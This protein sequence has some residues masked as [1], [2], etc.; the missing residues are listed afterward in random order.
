MANSGLA[1]LPPANPPLP[2]FDKRQKQAPQP[3]ALPADQAAAVAELRAQLPNLTVD[4]EPVTGSP[5]SVSAVE[6]FLSGAGGKGKAIS[7]SGLAGIAVDD[8]Y[9][10]TK[11][12]LQDHRR[13][14]GF[15]PE[16]LDNARITREFVTA[17]NGLRT[18]VWEQ[19]AEGIAVFEAVLISHTTSKSELVNISSQFVPDPSAAANNGAP[20]RAALVA[21]SAVTASQAVALAAQNVGVELKAD[22]VTAASEPAAG[23]EQR[24]KFKAPGLKGEADAKLIWLPM[25]KN[26]LRLCWDVILMSRARGEMFRVLVYVQTGEALLRRCLTSYLSDASYR[27]YTSDSPSPFSPGYATPVTTQ[28]PLVPRALVTLPALSTNASPLGWIND[29]G[30]E[31]LGNNVDAHTDWNS[32]DLP[33]L[34]R[35]QGSPFRVFDFPMDLTTQDPTNYSQA[36][37][38]QLFYLCNWYHDKLY[39]LGFTEAAGNFQSNNFARGG[40]GNDAVQADAQDGSGTDNANF[41]TPP[42]GYPGRMQMFIFTGMSP[43]RDGDLDAEVVLHEYTHGLSNRRVGGGVGISALQS[44]GMGEGWSDFY[45]LAL[46][47]EAG[48]DVN[49]NYASGAYVSYKIGGPSDL[50]NYYFGIR[51]YPYTTA[52]ARNPL[53]F[54]DIDPAQADYCSSGAPYHTTMFGPCGT[55]DAAEVHNS[56]EVWCVTLWEARANLI[57]R[58]GW[59][60]GNQLILQLVTDGMNLSP[61]NPTFLQARDAILQADLADNG[62]ANQKELWAAFAKRGMG[63]SATSPASSITAGVH[64]SFDLPDDLRITPTSGFTAIGPVGG[65]FSP[66]AI[67]IILTNVGTNSFSWT[68][69]NTATWLDVS[70]AGGTLTP[71]GGSTTVTASVN[72]LASSLPMGIYSSTV[73]F[74]NLSSH[75]GQSRQFILRVGQP[76]YYTELFDS[77]TNDLAFQTITFTPDGSASFYSVC[78]SVAANFPTDP[79]GGTT[80]SLSDDSYT[81]VTLTGTNTAAIYNTR[82]NILYIGSNG[83]LTMNAG[84]SY[85]VESFASHFNL[86]RVSALFHDLNPGVSGTVSWKQLADR[87]A[88]TFQ[89]VCEY[90]TTLPNS[91]Q[92]EMFFD[93][94]IRLTYLTI[95]CQYDLV[96][97]S[98]GQGVPAGFIASD[99]SRYSICVPPDALV[100]TPDADLASQGYQGGPFTPASTTYTLSNVGT[101]SLHWSGAANQSWVTIDLSGGILTPGAST[102]ITVL[103]NANAQSLS[104]GTYNASVTFSNLITGFAQSRA[105]SLSVVAIP[106]SIFV[107]DSI[108]PEGDLRMPFGDVIASVARTEQITVINTDHHHSLVITNIALTADQYAEDFND[109][110]AQG[111][112]P[113]IPADWQVVSGEYR[114]QSIDGFMFSRY[115]G[116]EWADLTVQMSCRRTGQP[117]NSAAVV[118]RATPDFD[119]SVGSGYVF[120]ITTSGSYG[121]WKQV[122]GASSWLQ[123]WTTSPAISASTNVLAAVAQGSLLSFYVNGILIWSGTDTALASGRIGLGGYSDASFVATHYFDNVIV[124]APLA[125]L[126]LGA[127]QAWYNQQA[128]PGGQRAFAPAAKGPAYPGKPESRPTPGTFLANLSATNG[129]WRLDNLPN[130]PYTL[131]PYGVLTLDLTYSPATVASNIAKVVIDS[132]DADQPR[133]EVQLSGQGIADY[134]QV[135]PATGFA[136]QGPRGGPFSPGS[137]R[138]VLS[139]TSPSTI[140]WSISHPQNWV[141][142]SATNGTL[143]AN[144]SVT[145][146]VVLT[147][148]ANALP[149]GLQSDSLLFTNFTTTAV[150]RRG[151][152]LNVQ[153]PFIA[154]TNVGAALLAESCGSGNGA[155]DPWE[156]VTV[157]LGLGNF[158]NIPASNVVATLLATGGVILP[159]GP[160]SYGTLSAGGSAVSNAFTFTAIGTCGGSLVATLQLQSGTTNL[161]TVAF[162]FRLGVPGGVFTEFFSERF[163]GV[164]APNLPPGWTASLSGAGTPWA[165]TTA[166]RD[167]LPNA[168]FAPDP[169]SPSENWLTSPS[170]YLPA[171][172]AQLKFRH[173]Y[174]TESCCDAGGLQISIAGG[175]FAD[176]LAA[177]GSFVTN[178]YSA[179]IGWRGAS[180]GYPG[181]ISTI[182]NLPD[183]TANQNIQLR[184]RFTSD[185]SVAGIGW[186]VDT[187]SVGGD[188]TCCVDPAVA[189]HFTWDTIPSPQCPNVPFQVTIRARNDADGAATNFTGV[190]ALTGLGSAP[191]TNT[192]LASPVFTV[193][194]SGTFTFGYS[195]I[196]NANLTVT[197]LRHCFGTKVSIWTDSGTL[198]ASQSVSSTPG[199][200]VETALS[201]PVQLTAGTTY[202]VAAY[203]GGGSYYWRTDLGT[204]FPNG[205]INQAYYSTVDG[206]PNNATP[207][208]RWWF[209]DLRYTVAPSAPLAIIPSVSANFT[210]GV[211]TGSITVPQVVPNLVLRADDGLRPVALANSIDVVNPPILGTESYGDFLLL[212]WPVWS[213]GSP[214][215]VLETATSLS[216]ETW[217]PIANPPLQIEDIYVVPVDTSEPQRYYRLR[218]TSP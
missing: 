102:N 80:L 140:N 191:V 132:N 213:V 23:P 16:A 142:V 216:P 74:F 59:A 176:I 54:K 76:D 93:G 52:M 15:G 65:P 28:P 197:H 127:E 57:N 2:N 82:R 90:G 41:S 175:A 18:V 29:G 180:A 148:L 146:T 55:S 218:L 113:D 164:T 193:S 81:S 25:D 201:S 181:F 147:A 64:E 122:G 19:Q 26:T 5:K 211:W 138:Y 78:R 66:N 130:F 120:Q 34:P 200:W 1:F 212:L 204:T 84:D 157:K 144:A 50:Q 133:T 39:E 73:L 177:G 115:A 145:V 136:S 17:H 153:T 11:A 68:N 210:Q 206:F 58:Y 170:F 92:I 101:N 129:P 154:V 184:W 69:I 150:Q 10:I 77:T 125:L 114:A 91:F 51:R 8:P 108:P 107:L 86:P 63:F 85:M 194:G 6:E 112:V 137:T 174:N 163:D 95:N 167:T 169:S 217:V 38:V 30:N 117:G 123:S 121:V 24:Q 94:R 186:Y 75:V 173:A 185:S 22:G 106:G 31:T 196:P 53:T 27:V 60:V 118:L 214:T 198:V 187:V 40:L 151:V 71:G 7:A 155:I 14:F 135:T 202:R 43:R 48:D 88:V 111:W 189:T 158:G 161:G 49:G 103:I 209:V 110:L 12:F 70:P 99:F 9:R 4:F 183:A 13:L 165:A 104:S 124:G 159:S 98:A 171:G 182:A 72:A 33:D 32:D 162:S 67:S 188:Y 119:D 134:L 143:A 128:V 207:N 37:A 215:F 62:G 208:A 203:T 96:G 168:V 190:L 166:L 36:A 97:L 199:T 139:N 3:A 44:E 131:P 141:N 156:T 192:I 172:G 47:S 116:Q 126:A 109:G 61:P 79:T 83:Y 179:G 42:D 89:G 46:L 105:V 178:G 45:A 205:T 195:F 35:P 21:A 152:T 87:A 160:K 149:V 100:V 56:G 20:N